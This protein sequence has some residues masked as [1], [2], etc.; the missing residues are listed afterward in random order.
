MFMNDKT[1][2][3]IETEVENILPLWEPETV[4]Y[5]DQNKESDP[6]ENPNYRNLFQTILKAINTKQYLHLVYGRKNFSTIYTPIHLD[7][8]QKDDTFRLF[9]KEIKYPI[10]LRN[11]K[12]CNITTESPTSEEESTEYETLKVEIFDNTKAHYHFNRAIRQ[13]SYF[14]KSCKKTEKNNTYEMSVDY[15]KSDESEIVIKVLMFGPN[16]KVLA[17]QSVIDDIKQRVTRQEQLFYHSLETLI[18]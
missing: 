3:A 4:K 8:S 5:F 6:F 7:Y 1:V 9:V 13:F 15:D 11:I 18:K 16:M 17:P 2:Q 10:N 14:K 12:E